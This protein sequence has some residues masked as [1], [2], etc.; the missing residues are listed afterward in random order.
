ML[1][2][3]LLSVVMLNV[4]MLSVMGPVLCCHIPFFRIHDRKGIESLS[5]LIHV[6]GANLYR[7]IVSCPNT[8]MNGNDVYNLLVNFLLGGI[9]LH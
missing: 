1:N 5:F 3:V 8:R 6:R 4:I 9:L 2:A 7:F